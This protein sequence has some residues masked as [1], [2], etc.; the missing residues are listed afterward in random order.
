MLNA[1][2]NKDVDACTYSKNR[3]GWQIYTLS[4]QGTKEQAFFVPT[5]LTFPPI[6]AQHEV[7]ADSLGTNYATTITNQTIIT[8]NY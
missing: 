6:F 4:K 7:Y 8:P 5:I 2:S 3:I 1:E